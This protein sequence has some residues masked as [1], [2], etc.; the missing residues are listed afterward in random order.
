M[1]TAAC[2]AAGSGV[3]VTPVTV[4]AGT[5]V[6][7]FELFDR[8]TEGGGQ[9]ADLD[10]ALLN[11]AGNLVAYSGN[12]GANESIAVN[13]PAAGTYKLCV[14][15]YASTNKVSTNYTL[16]SAVVT[17]TDKG[18]NFKVLL[19]AKVY[20]G[21]TA[22][23]SAAWSG[24]AAGKRFLGAAQMLDPNGAPASTTVFQVETNNPIPLGEPV[25]R[26]VVQQDAGI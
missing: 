13:A 14:V 6:A 25:Q 2:R 1:V 9:G 8:D 3:R 17:S 5:L 12:G 26:T 21:S 7:Q 18:G 20:A 11:P 16:S 22:T 10:M 4:P 24:L 15:G 23:L 19:P